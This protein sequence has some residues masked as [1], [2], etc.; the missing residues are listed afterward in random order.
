MSQREDD[1]TY[2]FREYMESH[3]SFAKP[4]KSEANQDDED[5]LAEPFYTSQFI[6]PISGDEKLA[7]FNADMHPNDKR[8]LLQGK[9]RVEDTLD[10][11]GLTSAEAGIAIHDFIKSCRRDGLR[12]IQIIHGRGR[13]GGEAVLK[14]KVNA[15]L[16]QSPYV[17][18]FCSCLPKHGGVGAVYILLR[19]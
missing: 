8:R 10:L 18:A 13:M 16:P 6:E 17:I 2:L 19:A 9:Y 7:F 4:T 14:T 15:W 11:H 3:P 1:D 5:D 12:C